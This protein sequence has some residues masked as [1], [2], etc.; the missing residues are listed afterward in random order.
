[1]K[2]KKCGT[3][4]IE[5]YLEI[6]NKKNRMCSKCLVDAELK[7]EDVLRPSRKDILMWG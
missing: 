6:R 3:K 2:C 1:M 5:G 7:G 4:L